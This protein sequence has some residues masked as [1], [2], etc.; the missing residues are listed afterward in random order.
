MRRPTAEV[1]MCV[2]S[3]ET[4]AQKP[5]AVFTWTVCFS[6]LYRFNTTID[7]STSSKI[8]FS[9]EITLIIFLKV[10]LKLCNY[11]LRNLKGT[12]TMSTFTR[13]SVKQ[14]KAE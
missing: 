14:F 1:R 4:V 3:R 8:A 12:H 5:I 10:C 13:G 11:I 6:S 7:F 9:A 2:K